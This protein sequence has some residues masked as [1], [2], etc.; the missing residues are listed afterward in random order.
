MK[1]FVVLAAAAFVAAPAFA[2]E[3]GVLKPLPGPEPYYS[4]YKGPPPLTV[5]WTG[6]YLG[7]HVG[8]A[9]AN[10]DFTNPFNVTGVK[11]STDVLITEGAIHLSSGSALVG[12]QVGCNLELGAK[13]LVGVEAD[14]AWTHISNSKLETASVTIPDPKNPPQGTLVQLSESF[15]AR[16]DF[17]GTATARLGY[18]LGYYNQ[19]LVYGKGGVAWANNKY[20]R[21]G[22]VSVSAC[23]DI[24]K[25]PPTCAAATVA[26]FDFGTGSDTRVGWTIG[27]GVEWALVGGWSIKGEYDY[28]NFGRRNVAFTESGPLI[29]ATASIGIKQ[30][31]SEFKVGLNYL[32]GRP[33]VN[34]PTMW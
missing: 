3:L 17:I 10:Y 28:L 13:W 2:A 4:Y 26:S 18:E 30:E 11:P 14:A 23:S 8:G 6:C 12:G 5:G 34:L 24:T 25:S 16:T 1:K 32:F 15:S 29:P 33:P 31:I 9:I 19:G 20:D 27:A 22:T 21:G 7:G